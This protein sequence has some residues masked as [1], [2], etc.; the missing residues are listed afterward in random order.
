VVQLALAPLGLL[1]HLLLAASMPVPV[2]L[3]DRLLVLA[4]LLAHLLL[5]LLVA[6]DP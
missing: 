1:A 3:L 4:E 2:V 5:V 6:L